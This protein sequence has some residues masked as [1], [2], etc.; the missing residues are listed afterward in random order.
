MTVHPWHWKFAF[1]GAK[2]LLPFAA[3]LRR[4]KRQFAPYRSTPWNDVLALEHGL[5]QV[6]LLRQAGAPLTGTVL[7]LGS[8]WMPIIPLVFHAAGARSLILTDVARLLDAGTVRSAKGV[9]AAG[10]ERVAEALGIDAARIPAAMA[11]FAFDYRV[12]FLPAEIP[13]ASVDVVVSRTVFEHIKPAA[14]HGLLAQFHRM[15]K[16]GG[17]M[18]H[19]ID[20]SDHWQHCD[21]SI[22]RLNFLRYGDVAWRLMSFDPI[23]Y[24]NRLRHGDYAA[25]LANAGFEVVAAE[26]EPDPGARREVLAMRLAPRFGKRSPDELAIL[27][28][29][30]VARKPARR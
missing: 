8:G 15:L 28:S 12:P 22:G 27:T 23:N 3:T 25:L 13:E 14:L 2:A 24:Q 20:N 17:M 1:D 4:L 11:T 9:I 7:E 29:Y 16:P 30:F 18:C 5:A 19:I 6:R 10:A 26:G 21:S